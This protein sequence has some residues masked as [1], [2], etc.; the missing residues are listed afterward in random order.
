MSTRGVS[1]ARDSADAILQSLQTL[2]KEQ[3]EEFRPPLLVLNRSSLLNSTLAGQGPRLAIPRFVLGYLFDDLRAACKKYEDATKD[4]L[5]SYIF[6]DP[7]GLHDPDGTERTG[8]Q[9]LQEGDISSSLSYA[10]LGAALVEAGKRGDEFRNQ[11]VAVSATGKVRVQ[12][13]TLVKYLLT[14]LR[15]RLSPF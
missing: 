14:G 8:F 6:V 2:R 3:G 1:V 13:L 9:L 15:S 5:L 10:D 4:N 11:A 12:Y 7:P